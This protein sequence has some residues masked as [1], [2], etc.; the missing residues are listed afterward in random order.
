MSLPNVWIQILVDAI[1]L[2]LLICPSSL[3][4][5][6]YIRLAQLFIIADMPW[7]L[8]CVWHHGFVISLHI[9]VENI[10]LIFLKPHF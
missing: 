8:N 3:Q 6:W 9:T 10:C 2:I 7:M 4:V 5:A 1:L